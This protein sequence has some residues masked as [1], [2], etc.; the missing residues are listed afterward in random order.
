MTGCDKILRN[1]KFAGEAAALRFPEF[2]L[3][4][5]SSLFSEAHEM[6]ELE[7][8]EGEFSQR[9]K[10]TYVDFTIGNAEMV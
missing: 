9:D 2:M 3:E 8:L 7:H 1:E 5:C 6:L 4:G 10:D